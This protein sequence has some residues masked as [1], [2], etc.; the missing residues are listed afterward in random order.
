MATLKQI[1]NQEGLSQ[2]EVTSSLGIA[3]STYSLY[4]TGALTPSVE[5]AICLERDFKQRIEWPDNVNANDKASIMEAL[6]SLSQHYPLNSVL[7]FAQKYLKEGMRIG[8]PGK[9]IIHF[10][11]ASKKFDVEPL[12]PYPDI[13]IE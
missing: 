5:D 9:L 10:A 8:D 1:R 3:L 11:N 2:A 12:Y 7:N 4:E 13:E 6:V